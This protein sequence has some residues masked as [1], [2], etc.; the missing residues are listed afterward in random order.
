MRPFVALVLLSLFA[1]YSVAQQGSEPANTPATPA[2]AAPQSAS[3]KD[4]DKN[5]AAQGTS[6]KKP[7]SGTSN[8]RL[9]GALPNF[10]TLEN[11]GKVQPLTSGQKFK[12]VA[13][14]AFD[15]VQYPW[16]GTLAGISQAENSEP[17]FG[18][19]AEGYAKRYASAFADGT[20]ENFMVGAVLPSILH[21]DP[22]FFQTSEGS[23]AHRAGYAVSRIFVTRTD[24]GR[25]QFNYSEIVG[26]ALSAAIS[27]NTYHPR[28]FITYRYNASTG[29]TM[30][31]FN[32]S[33]RT[34]SNTAS[35]WGTQVGYD[36]I[37][38]VIKE[39]WPDVRRKMFHKGTASASP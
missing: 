11:A 24:S 39:F 5:K 6:E 30:P 23:F 1:Y 15:K 16:Y 2:A 4:K 12:A 38:L 20:I 26:S 3:D 34:L 9:F 29:M 10:L 21:Q 17:G 27:T 19:G 14:G 36:T 37:T 25:S 31:V 33:D 18:Q 8:D 13:R 35:V 28:S 7:N 32:A 22:R